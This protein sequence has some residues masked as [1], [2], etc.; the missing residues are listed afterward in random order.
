MVDNAETLLQLI[1]VA[2]EGSFNN[3][4]PLEV[5]EFE[6]HLSTDLSFSFYY[7]FYEIDKISFIGLVELDYH[8]HINQIHCYFLFVLS[9]QF[10]HIELLLSTF[11]VEVL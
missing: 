10:H 6:Y 1:V 8:T 3:L 11:Q 4:F 7:W 9:E 5:A 2:L